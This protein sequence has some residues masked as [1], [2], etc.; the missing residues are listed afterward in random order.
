MS[1]EKG[2]A[3][4]NKIVNKV[5]QTSTIFKQ[6]S[7]NYRK[8]LNS[9]YHVLDISIEALY[10]ANVKSKSA[11]EREIFNRA[12]SSFIDAIKQQVSNKY[13]TLDDLTE[14]LQ[15]SIFIENPAMLISTSFEA[16]RRVV[17]AVSR[18]L[19]R[20]NK[21]F[22]ISDRTRKLD[23]VMREEGKTYEE[24]AAE[25]RI[26]DPKLGTELIVDKRTNKL[27]ARTRELSL[28]D[29]GHTPGTEQGR[30]SPLSEQL[31]RTVSA[32]TLLQRADF[33][34]LEFFENLS[35]SA[36]DTVNERL[37]GLVLDKLNALTEIQA[38]CQVSFK[39]EIP[40]KLS[41]KLTGRGGFLSLTLQL[42]T[43]NNQLSVK[44]SKV[45]NDLLNEIKEEL[46]KVVLQIPGS[47]TME[48]DVV[49]LVKQALVQGITGKGSAVKLKK[50]DL[51]TAAQS[52]RSKKAKKPAATLGTVVSKAGRKKPPV[53]KPV[54][55]D[56]GISLINLQNLINQQLQDVISA[57]M[58]DGSSRNVLN[59][60]TG[61]FASSAKVEYISESRAGMITA[62][63][64]YMKNPYAT[65]S[66]GGQQQYPRSRDPKL[67]ISKSIREIAATQV[68]NRLRAVN[69]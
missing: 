61:R 1:A 15:G 8:Q 13:S 32:Q 21:Y 43:V 54:Q 10:S 62:F 24:L 34:E 68:G 52:A 55:V 6:L 36:I 31:V 51:V 47:D 25:G 50:H 33:N 23:E 4:I 60:R 28:V 18:R 48:Q 46:R 53:S 69:V 49:N 64:S 41:E 44:E 26:F 57:N 40:E 65:F 12:Y 67:L 20:R 45:R 59:Y 2:R 14:L 39:N 19:G 16:S 11:R 9:R 66:G 58:G 22:G 35:D 37:Y 5:L 29:L 63:Y 27:V 3:E 7:S 38:D 30:D 56:A 17:S 42:Y